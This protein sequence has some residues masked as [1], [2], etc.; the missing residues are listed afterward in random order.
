[1]I[2]VVGWGE[3]VIRLVIPSLLNLFKAVLT[4]K[5]IS[6]ENVKCSY[7]GFLLMFLR[8]PMHRSVEHF[9]EKHDVSQKPLA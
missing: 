9:S 1:M 2:L 6:V 8:C 5:L 7:I 4:Q 3:S